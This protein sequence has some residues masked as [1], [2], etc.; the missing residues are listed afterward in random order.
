MYELKALQETLEDI[1]KLS[2]QVKYLRSDEYRADLTARDPVAGRDGYPSMFGAL[3]A[4][5]D[6]AARTARYALATLSR[7]QRLVGPMER[8]Q[9]VMENMDIM[10]NDENDRELRLLEKLDSTENYDKRE[11]RKAI[12]A[13]L[14]EVEE[15]DWEEERDTATIAL[16]AAGFVSVERDD[17]EGYERGD[18]QITFEMEYDRKNPRTPQWIGYTMK[19][20]RPDGTE[21][22]SHSGSFAEQLATIEGVPCDVKS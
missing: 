15:A 19:Y 6:H 17:F 11:L 4:H 10:A 20:S 12:H 8:L 9:T 21:W 22:E 3:T 13:A 2:D 1:S 16:E 14:N 18:E 5:A 7:L